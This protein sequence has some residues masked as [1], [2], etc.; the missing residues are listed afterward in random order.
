M[1]YQEYY[2]NKTLLSSSGNTKID[3][4]EIPTY[5]LSLLPHS[6]NSRKINLCTF[7]TKEC[8]DVCLNMAGRGKFNNVQ[9]ARG[10]KTEF[11]INKKR[12][13]LIMLTNELSKINL[14]FPLAL[15]RLNT[16]SDIN[17]EKE[18]NTIGLSITD[19]ANI[20][21]YNY[22]K[23]PSYIKTRKKNEEYTFSFSGYNWTQCDEFLKNKD[24]NVAVVF[25]KYIPTTYK[26][27]NVLNGDESDMRLAKYDGLG[28]II[29]LKLKGTKTINKFIIEQ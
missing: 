14:K 20:I 3:K 19:F 4:N 13:F 18:F 28:N 5:N 25:E 10:I 9:K 7:S 15:I 2:R 29:G 21:S 22:T 12:E 6:L 11:F 27:F 23:N 24:C 16:F 8:R 26:G 17:W 1:N